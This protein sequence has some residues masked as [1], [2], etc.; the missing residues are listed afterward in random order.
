MRRLL[1]S[2]IWKAAIVAG[3]LVTPAVGQNIPEIF[4]RYRCIEACGC[5]PQTQDPVV[6]QTDRS[7]RFTNECGQESSGQIKSSNSFTDGELTGNIGKGGSLIFSNG[8]VWIRK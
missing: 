3:M 4:G 1:G 2:A 7:L 5:K 6:S 8:T